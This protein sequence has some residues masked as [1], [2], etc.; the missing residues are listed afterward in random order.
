VLNF[1]LTEF[2]SSCIHQD[3]EDGGNV[4][5]D[6]LTVPGEGRWEQVHTAHKEEAHIIQNLT[7]RRY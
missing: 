6:N 2:M 3:I 4:E 1:N 7:K 5:W